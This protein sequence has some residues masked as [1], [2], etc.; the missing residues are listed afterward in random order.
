MMLRNRSTSTITGDTEMLLKSN[1][2]AMAPSST[3]TKRT[4]FRLRW[5]RLCNIPYRIS[6]GTST[7]EG[8]K[9]LM[10]VGIWRLLNRRF[11]RYLT[12]ARDPLNGHLTISPVTFHSRK[13][14]PRDEHILDMRNRR[15]G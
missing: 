3:Q 7:S 2:R 8:R 10:V 4:R 5:L 9:S 1:G 15:R 13:L 11:V 14:E 12:P 6:T